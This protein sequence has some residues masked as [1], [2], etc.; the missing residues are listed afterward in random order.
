[1]VG[2]TMPTGICLWA[3]YLKYEF[4]SLSVIWVVWAGA[5]LRRL[6]VT[7]RDDAGELGGEL[8]G[9]LLASGGPRG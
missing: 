4:S 7:G 3:W 5:A 6:G 2:S 1:M 9:F 8:I